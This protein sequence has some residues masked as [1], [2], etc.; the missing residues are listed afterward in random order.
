MAQALIKLL[1]PAS[2]GKA[3]RQH[4]CCL[5]NTGKKFLS[6]NGLALLSRKLVEYPNP[7]NSRKKYIQD[8]CLD[9]GYAGWGDN[10]VENITLKTGL[11]ETFFGNL[12]G[13]FSQEY[14]L[15]TLTYLSC[16]FAM[17][18]SSSCQ[19]LEGGR[20]ACDSHSTT[21]GKQHHG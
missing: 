5:F 7:Y 12:K 9:R 1:L 11:C 20:K 10:S 3:E 18:S 14:T 16:M 19:D 13:L 2:I 17:A 21:Q 6:I 15:P 4:C 8:Y